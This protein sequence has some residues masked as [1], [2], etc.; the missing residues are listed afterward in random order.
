MAKNLFENFPYVEY[1]ELLDSALENDIHIVHQNYIYGGFTFAW[2]R[3]SDFA[4]G[5]MVEVSVAFCSPRD[6]FCRKI[7]AYHALDNF[8]KNLRIQVPVGD[9]DAA[10]IVMRLRRMFACSSFHL[11][12]Y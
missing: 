12:D 5:R 2:R 11:Y 1:Q 8:D 9:K 3:M 4:K 10:L 6:Q 7:G